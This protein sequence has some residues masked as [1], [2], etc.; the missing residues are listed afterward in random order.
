MM[1]AFLTA[2]WK[3]LLIFNYETDVSTLTPYLPRGTELDDYK[4]EYYVSIVGFH[5]R[6][7]KLKGI[8]IPFHQNFEELNLRFYVRFKEGS[9]WKRGV[10]FI[11]EIVP[12]AMIA[13]VANTIY[14]EH[15]SYLPMKH[16]YAE[17]DGKVDVCYNW[18]FH[19]EW[20][21]ISAIADR[22]TQILQ[23]ESF[24]EFITEHYWGYAKINQH[25]TSEYQV[26]HPCWQIHP[27]QSY[28]FHCNYIRELYGN[29]FY[30]CLSQKP[31]S[32]FL[33]NGSPVKVFDRK[34]L[35]Y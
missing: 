23:P 28:Q 26:E 9:Q 13:F 20:S 27:L 21:S 24:E 31:V 29:D 34:L 18:F 33:A 35:R 19:N 6:N 1:K 32:V 4:G 14:G 8:G 17:D 2:E 30:N 5:F 22:D 7:T 15:Y 3:N 25:T 16:L 10:V 12:K 11:K